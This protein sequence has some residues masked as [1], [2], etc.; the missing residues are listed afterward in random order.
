ME[1]DRVCLLDDSRGIYIP[2]VFAESYSWDN[3][4]PEDIDILLC[5]PDHEYYW[6]AWDSVLQ[7]A[8]YV[9]KNGKPW[10]L[11]QEGDLFAVMYDND[12]D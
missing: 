2:K 7:S 12:N 11:Y 6:D 8:R 5:G 4:N 9:D 10:R 1:D 3:V